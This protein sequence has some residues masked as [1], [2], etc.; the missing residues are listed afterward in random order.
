VSVAGPNDLD[1]KT[2]LNTPSDSQQQ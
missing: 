2:P 1:F